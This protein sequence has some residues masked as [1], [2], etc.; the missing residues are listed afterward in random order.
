V[1]GDFIDVTLAQ[2][3]GDDL[4]A[5]FLLGEGEQA[6]AL[7]AESLELVGRGAGFERAA[8]QDGRARGLDGARGAE[9]LL[10]AFH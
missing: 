10:F 8:A 5:G 6:Q 2:H 4:E 9:E 7:A 1:T 3:F